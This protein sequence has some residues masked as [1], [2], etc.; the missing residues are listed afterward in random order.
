MS[1]SEIKNQC[2]KYN[3]LKKM[4]QSQRK[5]RSQFGEVE[6]DWRD[7][8]KNYERL[9]GQSLLLTERQKA[10]LGGEQAWKKGVQD[11]AGAR[12]GRDPNLIIE[13]TDTN[14]FVKFV[15]ISICSIVSKASL[16]SLYFISPFLTS[17]QPRT[18][19]FRV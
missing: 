9:C 15:F 17:L 7:R 16:C 4:S 3:R 19:Y 1:Q 10:G 8:E 14:I 5:D 2:N 13:F 18:V 12:A 6:V 11:E